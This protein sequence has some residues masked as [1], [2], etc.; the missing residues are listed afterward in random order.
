[1]LHELASPLFTLTALLVLGG[2]TYSAKTFFD[3]KLRKLHRAGD[4]EA[5]A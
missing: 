1:M 3:H 4:R 2:V 5:R